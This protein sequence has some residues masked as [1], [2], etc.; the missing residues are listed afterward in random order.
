MLLR[1][2]GISLN[3]AERVRIADD[4]LDIVDVNGLV[5]PST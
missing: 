5:L 4:A 3:T 1:G 2:Q